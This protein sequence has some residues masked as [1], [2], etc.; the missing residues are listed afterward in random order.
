MMLFYITECHTPQ[1]NRE[2]ESKAQFLISKRS[3]ENLHEIDRVST[4]RDK[5]ACVNSYL[6]AVKGWK[7]KAS[8]S[9]AQCVI[10]ATHDTSVT[11]KQ[12]TLGSCVNAPSPAKHAERSCGRAFF[13]AI[14]N[15]TLVCL[16]ILTILESS[17]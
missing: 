7:K 3:T 2:I 17:F 10:Q 8:D 15:T 9:T 16:V 11:H 1:R 13:S 4:M 5:V 14:A 6:L 12:C